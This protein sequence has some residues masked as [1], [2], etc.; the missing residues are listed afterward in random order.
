M[1]LSE[2]IQKLRKEQGLTQ[3]QFAEQ[4][5]VSRTAV[6]KWETGRGIP[7]MES[8]KQIANLFHITLDQLLST[9][10]IVVIAESENK[11]NIKRF[12]SYIDGIINLAALLGLLL[13]LYKIEDN[14]FFYSVPLYQLGGWQRIVFW[15]PPVIMMICGIA[16]MVL[17]VSENA[18]M[19]T[20]ASIVGTA[21]HVS[22]TI[23][24]ILCGHPYPAVLF[25][26]LFAMKGILLLKKRQ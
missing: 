25:F 7:S 12:A 18:K 17:A 10:E 11:E 5:F 15:I 3:E 6:S 26:F 24:L 2:K 4:L 8:L 19:N 23:L 13:P 1:K 9:E 16:Q 21:A 14:G 22:A 20:A